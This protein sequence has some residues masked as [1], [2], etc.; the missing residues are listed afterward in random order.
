MKTVTG[1]AMALSVLFVAATTAISEATFIRQTHE[2]CGHGCQQDCSKPCGEWSVSSGRAPLD[3]LKEGGWGGEDLSYSNTWDL[4]TAGFVPGSNLID[5]IQVWFAFAD[6]QPN[7]DVGEYVD[8]SVGGTTLWDDLEVDGSHQ[9]GYEYHS[10][11]LDP[12]THASIFTD[13][14]ADG[15]LSYNVTLQQLLEPDYTSKD[16]KREDTY[17]KVAKIKAWENCRP[18]EDTPGVPDGGTTLL[19]LGA[20]MTGLAGI[21]RALRRAA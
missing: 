7:G 12:T 11:V 5:G 8:I 13:L 17:L 20:S 14:Q 19:M 2:S 16:W 3:F 1:A 15:L 10:M 18:P 21:R 4:T 6:D 9:Y